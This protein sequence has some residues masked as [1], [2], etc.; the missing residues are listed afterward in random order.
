MRYAIVA[1]AL[2]VSLLMLAGPIQAGSLTVD[3]TV[4]WSGEFAWA[5]GLGQIDAI[6]GSAGYDAW[7]ITLSTPGWLSVLA[8]DEQVAGD[9]F[10]LYVDGA[11][12]PW[13]S[14]FLD[15]S[16]YYNGE[17]NSLYL[18]SGTHELTLHVTKLAVGPGFIPY[19]DGRGFASLS[20]VT[21]AAGAHMPEPVTMVASLTGLVGLAG[22]LRKRRQAS[23]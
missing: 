10:A 16:N 13:A 8:K 4:G 17:V 3:P 19:P 5:D 22:Y 12:V 23:A 11:L 9:E 6:G 14:E 20:R 7:S 18:S 15:G 1:L 2:S 21:P